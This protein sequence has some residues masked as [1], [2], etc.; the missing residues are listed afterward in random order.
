MKTSER[1]LLQAVGKAG[2]RPLESVERN[3][4]AEAHRVNGGCYRSEG[5]YAGDT[6][7]L[8]I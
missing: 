8:G 1:G 3:K 7:H 6:A 2:Q 5:R 4:V